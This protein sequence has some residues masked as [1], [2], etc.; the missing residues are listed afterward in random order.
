MLD[1]QYCIHCT[2]KVTKT[3]SHM[4]GRCRIYVDDTGRE[5]SGNRCPDCYKKHKLTY[6]AKRRL[7]KGHRPLGTIAICE[8]CEGQFEVVVGSTEKCLVC[9]KKNLD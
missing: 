2:E 8:Q 5:W 3:F 4:R 1:K 9:R 6:D 7:K